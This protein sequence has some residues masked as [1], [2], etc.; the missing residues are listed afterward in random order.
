MPRPPVHVRKA[1][2]PPRTPYVAPVA[3]HCDRALGPDE[4]TAPWG[5]VYVRGPGGLYHDPVTGTP[6]SY[7]ALRDRIA[8]HHEAGRPTWSLTPA[9]TRYLPV[10]GRVGVLWPAWRGGHLGIDEPGGTWLVEDVSFE[11]ARR[12][13]E[14]W[15]ADQPPAGPVDPAAVARRLDRTA[16]PREQD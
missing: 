7:G 5:S 1:K 4:L 13:V 15:A 10:D 2:R 14:Q 9:G 8:R 3:W 16:L 11:H 6:L 12:L